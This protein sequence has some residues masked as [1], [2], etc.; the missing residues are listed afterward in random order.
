MSDMGHCMKRNNLDYYRLFLKAK[1]QGLTRQLTD[2][3][4]EKLQ[5][6]VF[7]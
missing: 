3:I 1:F 7:Q 4:S 2:K 5:N 6:G